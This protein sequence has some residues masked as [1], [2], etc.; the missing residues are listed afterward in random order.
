MPVDQMPPGGG[1]GPRGDVLPDPHED[2]LAELSLLVLGR[3]PADREASVREHL[4]ECPI[5]L[6]ELPLLEQTAE[7]LAAV[8]AE[9]FLD[10]PPEDAQ[11]LVR[12]TVRAIRARDGDAPGELSPDR[13]EGPRVSGRRRTP[14]SPRFALAAAAA[15]VLAVAVG[16]IGGRLSAPAATVAEPPPA[17]TTAPAPGTM[18]A[19]STDP[20]TGARLSVKVIPAAGWV[21]ITATTSGIAQGEKCRLVVVDRAGTGT[22]A[23]SWLVS[24][25]GAAR[26]TTLQGSAIV[27]PAQVAAVQVQ[28]T[29]GHVLVTTPI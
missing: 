9:A 6:A 5:C 26:G 13:G 23:G 28:N 18:F 20:T 3:L 4:L 2:A 7:V 21:R 25:T 15:I 8:E 11:L 19:T 1:P 10:G 24:A 29:A 16:A 22:E 27:D 17:S 12:R 14:R